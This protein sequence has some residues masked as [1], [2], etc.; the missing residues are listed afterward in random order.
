MSQ[1]K[2]WCFTINNFTVEEEDAVRALE[3][4]SNV[5]ALCAEE[6]HLD[7]GTP[8]IQGYV[9]FINKLRQNSLRQLLGGRA[10]VEVAKGSEYENFQYCSKENTIIAEKNRPEMRSIKYDDAGALQI[11]N[12]M[13]QLEEGDFEAKYP[14]FYLYNKNKYRD[15]RHEYLI[16]QQTVWEGELKSKNF[17]VWGAPGVGKSLSARKGIPIINI[18]SKPFNKWWNGYDPELTK[19]VIIDDW[20]NMDSG[21]DTLVQHLKIWADRYPFTAEI[22]G[23]SIAISPVFNLIVT[24]NYEPALCFHSSTDVD[25][26]ERRFTVIELKKADDLLRYFDLQFE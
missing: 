5:Q 26:I 10:H 17:W 12:D 7:E 1:A 4:N 9:H 11:I 23:G 18:Y 21:G 6:E 25:A 14:R 3:S 8:H 20:P 13:R 24:S 15:F 22:K 16:K 19:R 2:R